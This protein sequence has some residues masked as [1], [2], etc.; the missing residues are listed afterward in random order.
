MRDDPVTTCSRHPPRIHSGRGPLPGF[1]THRANVS[2]TSHTWSL[3]ITGLV[4]N[5]LVLTLDEIQKQL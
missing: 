1:P 2:L 3:P 4:D 5:P